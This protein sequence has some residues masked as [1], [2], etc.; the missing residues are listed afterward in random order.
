MLKRRKIEN[1]A[2]RKTQTDKLEEYNKTESERAAKEQ[3]WGLYVTMLE[4]VAT[5]KKASPPSEL[6]TKVTFWQLSTVIY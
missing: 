4:C 6:A 5:V 2:L 1:R 3:R